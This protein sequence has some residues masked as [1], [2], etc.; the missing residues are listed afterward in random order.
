[1]E[2]T[3]FIH[4]VSNLVAADVP[5]LIA[6]QQE[7]LLGAFSYDFEQMGDKLFI[8]FFAHEHEKSDVIFHARLMDNKKGVDYN[9]VK[10]YRKFINEL[11]K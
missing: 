6:L 10:K 2:K 8:H 3:K 9:E 4:L 11:Q 7:G 1:M 5:T